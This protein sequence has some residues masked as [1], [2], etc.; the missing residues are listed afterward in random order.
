MSDVLA[1]GNL[2]HRIT[3]LVAE[4]LLDNDTRRQV[5]TLL[6]DETLADAAVYMDTHRD[7]L[8]DR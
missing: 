3:G 8:K 1:W 4:D 6:G 2:G 7:E 5:E